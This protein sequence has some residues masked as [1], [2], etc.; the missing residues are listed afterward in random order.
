MLKVSHFLKNFLRVWQTFFIHSI[1]IPPIGQ[2]SIKGFSKK[3]NVFLSINDSNSTKYQ[4]KGMY[5]D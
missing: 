1:K 3:R 5:D 2:V 4:A